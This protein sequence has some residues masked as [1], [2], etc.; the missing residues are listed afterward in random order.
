MNGAEQAGLR[1]L[2]GEVL[3]VCPNLSHWCVNLRSS[4][5]VTAALTSVEGPQSIRQ[6]GRFKQMQCP[7]ESDSQK[8]SHDLI[9]LAPRRRLR[10]LAAQWRRS[11]AGEGRES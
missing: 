7:E 3:V 10:P 1:R 2:S 4:E 9:E 8:R 6:R 11:I 5:R